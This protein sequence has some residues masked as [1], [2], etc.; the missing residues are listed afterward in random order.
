VL[1]TLCR[2]GAC[3]L[4]GDHRAALM[5]SI[6]KL[7]DW[8]Q[9]RRREEETGQESLFGSDPAESAPVVDGSVSVWPE[10]E[11]LRA[12]KEALGFFL[13]GNPLSE[14]ED[15]LARVTTHASRALR[16]D[17]PAQ[18]TVGGLVT[19][20]KR[21]KIKSGPNAG[22]VMARF[23]LEDLEGTVDVAVFAEALRRFEDLI[24]EDAAVVVR[25]SVRE[26]GG[27]VELTLEEVTSLEAAARGL[28]RQLRLALTPVVTKSTLV[29]LR[30]LLAEH[31]GETTI[32][33]GLSLDESTD[34]EI[35]PEHRFR[36]E[37]TPE[38][39]AAIEKLIGAGS[40]AAIGG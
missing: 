8:A 36:V 33:F 5:A 13:T 39:T 17:V 32:V 3:D 15:Q 11:R 34:V 14:Y 28:V 9:R 25:G 37:N 27:E 30:D 20:V 19:R 4:F 26:R 16:Q 21:I 12:E 38:L 2:S 6:P 35:V 10:S 7:A 18:V 40:V 29:K 24:Q 1:E 23:V 31:P 22:K